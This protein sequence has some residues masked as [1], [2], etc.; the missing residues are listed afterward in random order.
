MV[1][2]SWR[3]AAPADE[4]SDDV[5]TAALLLNASGVLREVFPKT[6]HTRVTKGF[7][8]YLLSLTVFIFG[9]TIFASLWTES[10]VRLQIIGF[11]VAYTAFLFAFIFCQV[12]LRVVRENH[13]LLM[14]YCCGTRAIPIESIIE[15]RA[16]RRRTDCRGS[17]RLKY[18]TKCFWGYPTNLERNII[19][20]TDT[21]CNNYF[22]CL[23]EMDEFIA[24]NWPDGKG[25]APPIAALGRP[26][27]EL[28]L[29]E[30]P[31]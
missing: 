9:Y 22:F 25:S 17:F 18:P 23:K 1:A 16:V 20:V 31:A 7:A 5:A 30:V 14:I 10:R 3:G 28:E 13:C 8:L 29:A 19:V 15:V 24:D 11:D 12:P 4:D 2:A 21:H 26:T 6:Y 27:T